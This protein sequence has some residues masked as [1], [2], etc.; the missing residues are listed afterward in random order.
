[1]DAVMHD[2]AV[3]IASKLRDVFVVGVEDG[4]RAWVEL[5]DQLVFCAR[6]VGDGGKEFQVHGA[7][8]GDDADV[9]MSEFRKRSNL[10]RVRHTKFKDC[11]LLSGLK[12]QDL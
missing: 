6:N 11:D 12:L 9:G 5:L 3:E 4:K 1:M 10:A 7:N 2:F 8:V